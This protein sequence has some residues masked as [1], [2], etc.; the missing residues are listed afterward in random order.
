MLKPLILPFFLFIG[1]N[2]SFGQM[3]S[4]LVNE[5]PGDGEISFDSEGNIYVNDSG[6]NGILNGDKVYKVTPSGDTSLFRSNLPIWVVGSTFDHNGNLLV[7]GWQAGKIS[8]ISSDGATSTVIATGINGA[9]SLEIDA[10]ENIYVVEYL[11]NK[12][13]K[14]DSSGANVSDYAVG[15]P[16]QNPAG[17]AYLETSKKLYVSNWTNNKICVI[18]SNQVVS[19]FAEIPDPSVGP[20]KLFGGYLFACSPQYHKIYKINLQDSTDIQL[21]AGTGTLGNTDV[22]ISIA[23]FNTPTGIGS[24]DGDTFYIAETFEVTGRIRLIEGVLLGQHKLKRQELKL[25][26]NPST[27]SINISYPNLFS[28]NLQVFIYSVEGKRIAQPNYQTEKQTISINT[29]LMPAGVYYIKLV[30]ETGILFTE[31]FIKQ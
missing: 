8:R 17:L 13:L 30:D 24:L 28:S 21:F 23:T 10:D 14:F 5:F 20:I 31:S 22:D 15:F 6:E 16:I 2:F 11:T 19:T 4:T 9:G 29:S 1:I 18:D 25:F 26:P 3:V 12:V 7:T 27:N